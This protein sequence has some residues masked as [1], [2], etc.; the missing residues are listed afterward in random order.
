MRVAGLISGTSVDGIDVAIVD[1]QGRTRLRVEAFRTVPYPDQVRKAILAVS[2]ASSVSTGEISQLNFLIG[3]LF[4]R[5]LLKVCGNRKPDLIGSHGQTIYHQGRAFPCHGYR[6]A[7]TLQIGEPAVI[8][9]RAGVPVVADFR[10]ADM[11][12]GGQGAPLVPALDY[13]L[14]R[15][16]R[17]T[18]VGLNIGGIANITIIPGGAGP[19][20]VLAFDTGPGNML[21]DALIGRTT[22]W[23]QGFDRDG[24]LAARG[25]V[26]EALVAHLLGDD[27]FRLP[28]PKT[29]GREQYGRECVE[30]LLE[31]NLLIKDLI[32]TITALTADSIA[33]ALRRFCPVAVDDLVVSGGGLHNLFLMRRLGAGLPEV[34]L[35]RAE[36]F[37]I[38]SDGKEAVL[39]ALLAYETWHNRPGN[40]PSA[41]GARHPVVLGKLIR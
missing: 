21:I 22:M 16:R 37:G 4:A 23:K 5:A 8:A 6:V 34:R 1:I 32:A 35:M 10:T 25:R 17:R 24:R 7:S 14:Y 13:A 33:D 19:E 36:D 18:R 38:P 31:E 40:I 27:F 41:T 15:H 11:A 9:E 20:K 28:P 26:D 2:N 29:A 30:G 3:E 12:A 39:F